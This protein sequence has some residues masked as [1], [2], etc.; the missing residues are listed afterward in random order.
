MKKELAVIGTG[1][2]GLIVGHTV[3]V[4]KGLFAGLDIAIEER[5][6]A[7]KVQKILATGAIVAVGVAT[8]AINENQKLRDELMSR[9][10]Q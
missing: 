1:L 5:Q 9:Q 7:K 6:K 2:G 3:G 4:M 10:G 8:A